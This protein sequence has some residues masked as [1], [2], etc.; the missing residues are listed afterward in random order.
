MLILVV[1]IFL[2]TTLLSVKLYYVVGSKYVKL[3]AQALLFI[4]INVVSNFFLI[5]INRNTSFE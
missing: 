3:K 1:N 2:L 4:L 5:S